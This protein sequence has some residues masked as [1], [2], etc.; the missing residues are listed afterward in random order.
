[1]YKCL[2]LPFPDDDVEGFSLIITVSP[3][4]IA[5]YFLTA[6]PN[7]GFYSWKLLQSQVIRKGYSL[8][9]SSFAFWANTT[10]NYNV[11]GFVVIPDLSKWWKKRS[12]SN[13]L[14][15]GSPLSLSNSFFIHH[16]L[17]LWCFYS[18]MHFFLGFCAT[19]HLRDERKDPDTELRLRN[20][21][22]ISS[23]QSD[24]LNSLRGCGRESYK[25]VSLSF[26][27]QQAGCPCPY[28]QEQKHLWEAINLKTALL[29]LAAHSCTHLHIHMHKLTNTHTFAHSLH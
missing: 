20:P 16:N 1:M 24:G 23:V 12:V 14:S 27:F 25:N 11:N 26:T 10:Y 13:S 8:L 9:G 5:F 15:S 18:R 3:Q 22:C 6:Y 4:G 2:S 19:F 17:F 28:R 7:I 21:N 29:H